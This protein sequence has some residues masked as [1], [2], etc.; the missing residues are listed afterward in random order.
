MHCHKPADQSG[1]EEKLG[2]VLEKLDDPG[3]SES[4]PEVA[5][6]IEARQL[7]HDPFGSEHESPLGQNGRQRRQSRKG[8]KR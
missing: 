6:W 1:D 5:N 4:T 7:R 8:E 2:E 3:N